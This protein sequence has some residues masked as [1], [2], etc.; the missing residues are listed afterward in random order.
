MILPKTRAVDPDPQ[1][2]F[3]M[4]QLQVFLVWANFFVFFST[5]AS[6]N[7]VRFLKLDLD[8]H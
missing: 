1:P 4:D 2:F 3:L 6:G 8:P 5:T 7:F